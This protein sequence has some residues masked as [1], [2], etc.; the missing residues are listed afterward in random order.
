M[1]DVGQRNTWIGQRANA[2]RRR[3]VLRAALAGAAVGVLGAPAIVTAA[4]KTTL[5][6]A[7]WGE[8]I[9][10]QVVKDIAAQYNAAHPDVEVTVQATPNAQY[11][12]MLDTRIAGRDTPDLFRMEYAAVG[13]YGSSVLMDLAGKLPANYGADFLPTFWS[14]VTSGSKI[15]AIP[16]NLDTEAVFYN[17]DVFDALG[18]TPPKQIEQSWSWGEFIEVARKLDSAKKTPFAFGMAW[19]VTP[20]RW[21]QFLYQHG[22]Q[23]LSN[24]LKTQM[25][26]SK[27]SIETIQ[28]LQSWFTNK[29]VPASTAIKSSTDPGVLFANGTLAMVINGDWKIP[30]LTAAIGGRFKWSVTFLPRDKAMAADVG[31]SC[32]GVSRTSKFPDETV[33]FLKYLT[34]ADVQSDFVSRSQYLPARTSLLKTVKY[35]DHQEERRIF[36]DVAQTIPPQLVACVSIPQFSKINLKMGDELD[37]AFTAGQSPEITARNIASYTKSVL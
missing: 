33:D 9:P 3:S 17:I 21:L 6:F 35:M 18:I 5:S 26:D 7:L 10:V 28:W 12:Q 29:L 30:A 2:P 27:E 15:Y 22:G 11:Y 20:Y 13:R 19:Q 4:P 24:D 1:K 8:P 14:A 16:A 25:V 31:G 37:L 36:L 32:W 34:A 23:L